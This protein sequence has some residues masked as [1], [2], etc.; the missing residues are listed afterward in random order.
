MSAPVL[1]KPA[2]DEIVAVAWAQ[3]ITGIPAG[4]V[5][6]TLP[7]RDSWSATGFVQVEAIVGGTPHPE[8]PL[9]RPVL[10]YGCWAAPE[11]ISSTK[12]PWG[13]AFILA[14][15]LKRACESDS[16]HRSKLLVL[17]HGF[18]QVIVQDASV[19]FGTRRDRIPSPESYAHVLID[20]QVQWTIHTPEV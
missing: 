8:F 13:E 9:Y 20:I 1:P 5:A 6:R 3:S 19:I 10:Q 17:P 15:L 2:N 12:P 11:Q 16:P 18:E 4:K 14:E 7:R